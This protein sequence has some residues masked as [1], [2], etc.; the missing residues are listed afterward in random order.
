MSASVGPGR[1]RPFQLEDFNSKEWMS[2]HKHFILLTKSGKPVYTL[3]GNEES[4]SSLTGIISLL[5]GRYEQDQDD[6]DDVLKSLE[7]ING[8]RIM[9]LSRNGLYYCLYYSSSSSSSG[10]PPAAVLK[11]YLN[12]FHLMVVALTTQKQLKRVSPNFDLRRFDSYFLIV[13]I[14]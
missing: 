9:F 7:C 2:H 12:Y 13:V 10:P 11:E 8:S 1:I 3:Y 14:V 4:M 6:G 5:L